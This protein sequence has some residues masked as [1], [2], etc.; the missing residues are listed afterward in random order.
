MGPDQPFYAR[1][2]DLLQAVSILAGLYVAS[3][4]R[5]SS[6]APDSFG[7]LGAG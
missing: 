2:N 1:M 6:G 3:T 7:S 4:R 5:V